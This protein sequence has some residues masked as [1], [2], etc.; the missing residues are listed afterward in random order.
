M[1]SSSPPPPPDPSRPNPFLSRCQASTTS[2]SGKRPSPRSTGLRRAKTWSAASFNDDDVDDDDGA[3]WHMGWRRVPLSDV[4]NEVVGHTAR[5]Q[6]VPLAIPDADATFPSLTTP[7]P[8]TARRSV[9]L[10]RTR[11]ENHQLPS[12]VASSR[13]G[14][15][16]GEPATPV[17]P[18]LALGRRRSEGTIDSP[19][20]LVVAVVVREDVAVPT[21]SERELR[22]RATRRSSPPSPMTGVEPVRGAETPSS[23]AR[24]TLATPADRAATGTTANLRR[25]RSTAAAGLASTSP[26]SAPPSLSSTASSSTDSTLPTT[27]ATLTPSETSPGRTT[28]RRTFG[29]L[30]AL[31][32]DPFAADRRPLRRD[33]TSPR[34]ESHGEDAARARENDH[35][36]RRRRL[37]RRTSGTGFP[38]PVAQDASESPG[39][40][41]SSETTT[42]GRRVMTRARSSG[43]G[44]GGASTASSPS[45]SASGPTSR[46]GLR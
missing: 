38:I 5:L 25:T 4:T 33:P 21:A 14:E 22:P 37:R 27:P 42:T 11:S 30:A 3:R 15:Q 23:R 6:R 24:S 41:S 31:P 16:R 39:S 45:S 1:A 35:D 28:R 8:S 7:S 40:G 10:R 43:G 44:G 26:S 29:G 34:S 36:D 12:P 32:E 17:A 13:R 2:S 9:A 46:S 18:R 19:T 20:P